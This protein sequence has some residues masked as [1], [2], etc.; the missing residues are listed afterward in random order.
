M[1]KKKAAAVVVPPK[2]PDVPALADVV[3]TTHGEAVLK[4]HEAD[5]CCFLC[6]AGR[7]PVPTAST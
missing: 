3:R 6:L 4:V 7:C 1:F 2:L 5:R